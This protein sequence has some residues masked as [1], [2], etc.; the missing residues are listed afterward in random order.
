MNVWV[1]TKVW[2]SCSRNIRHFK[3]G[4][5]EVGSLLS[6]GPLDS[7]GH[8]SAEPILGDLSPYP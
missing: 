3:T 2:D 6:V 5:A 4:R 8:R 1:P 7:G